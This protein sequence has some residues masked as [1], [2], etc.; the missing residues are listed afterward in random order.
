MP[1]LESSGHGLRG[2]GLIRYSFAIVYDQ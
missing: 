1:G 2:S